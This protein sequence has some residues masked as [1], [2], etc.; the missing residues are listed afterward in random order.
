MRITVFLL[1]VLVVFAAFTEAGKKDK[2]EGG[3]NGEGNSNKKACKYETHEISHCDKSTGTRTA[4]LRLKKG[5]PETCA[6]EKTMTKKCRG[7]KGKK[8]KA[9]KY[10]THEISQCDESTGTRTSQL[11]LK[12]GDSKTCAPEK[13]VTR[14]C[15]GMKGKKVTAVTFDVAEVP[16]A[17]KPLKATSSTEN[18][19]V[20]IKQKIESNYQTNAI[21][22]SSS[23]LHGLVQ[24][25]H[26]A[27]GNHYPLVLSPDM[28]WLCI[29]QGLA[30]HINENSEQLR[31]K[32]VSHSGKKKIK[33]RRDDFVK[34]LATNP[35][36]EVFGEFS[37]KIKD[38][39]GVTNYDLITPNF[40][41]TG[42]MEKAVGDIA[43]MD[44]M[45]SY[46]TYTFMTL[47]GIPSITL[48]GTKEDWIAIRD[49]AEQL[50]QYDL[51][52]W[53]KEL[54]PVLDQ[55]VNASSGNIDKEFWCNI[56]K[57]IH[58]IGG[59][60]ITG[61]II[62]LFPYLQ[63]YRSFAHN[64]NLNKWTARGMF[65]FGARTEEFPSGLSK[66]PFQWLYHQQQFEMQF[67]G[68]FMAVSQDHETLA[69]RPELG[70]AV[71][72]DGVTSEESEH[73]PRLSALLELLGIKQ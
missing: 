63:D 30:I 2:I 43:L 17:T 7:M 40:T 70:W 9:C 73:D 46:S 35:W 24:A 10:E 38:E 20:R 27:Y 52:R 36:P 65:F 21:I 71:A 28:I 12:K 60:Y 1:V 57:E 67:I 25:V 14:K 44:T 3:E 31:E 45:P 29:T 32:F 69:L 39:I 48:E 47:Y 49:K 54:L 23:R 61:W 56:Y 11:R 26:M 22:V 33:V 41:T 34:G 37:E 13:N 72:E 5:D 19:T 42:P 66:A 58:G 6:P 53:T 8:V 4:Q 16:A 50:E 55:F 51:K 68:G 62:T 59:P 64:Q 18:L 15:K